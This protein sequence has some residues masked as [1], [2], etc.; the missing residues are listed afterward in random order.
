MADFVGSTLTDLQSAMTADKRIRQE[1]LMAAL[2]AA[3]AGRGY[4][5]AERIASRTADNEAERLRN[6]LMLGREQLGSAR[7]IE[8]MRGASAENIARGTAANEATRLQNALDLGREG[9]TSAENIERMRGANQLAVAK[10]NAMLQ[11]PKYLGNAEQLDAEI[12]QL[13]NNAKVSA[14]KANFSLESKKAGAKNMF[15][16][17]KVPSSEE[18]ATFASDIWSSATGDGS[19]QMFYNGK[20]FE[21]IVMP[22]PPRRGAGLEPTVRPSVPFVPNQSLMAPPDYGVPSV[23]LGASAFQAAPSGDTAVPVAPQSAPVGVTVPQVGN[24]YLN[25]MAQSLDFAGPM[26]APA[27]GMIDAATYLPRQAMANPAMAEAL[28]RLQQLGSAAVSGTVGRYGVQDGTPAASVAVPVAPKPAR[29]M[30]NQTMADDLTRLSTLG[31]VPAGTVAHSKT[32][33]I[34]YRFDGST[35]QPMPR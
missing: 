9:N 33:P 3:T 30:L 6:A 10:W 4:S 20:V 32:L 15:G 7:E 18:V 27:R 24:P 5:S 22:K 14:A 34:S 26:L 16:L 35:W 25:R 12:D 29:P 21:P 13:N 28:R 17:S 8:G 1:R 23:Q 2:Q 19:A 31:P 11:D